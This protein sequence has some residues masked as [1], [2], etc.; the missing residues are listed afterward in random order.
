MSGRDQIRLVGQASGRHAP[1]L[2]RLGYE[3]NAV[4]AVIRLVKFGIIRTARPQVDTADFF[5]FVFGV[6]ALLDPLM[7]GGVLNT[8]AAIGRHESYALE[9]EVLWMHSLRIISYI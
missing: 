8:V 5:F 1:I 9:R 4:E 3:I 6:C 2:L 7:I